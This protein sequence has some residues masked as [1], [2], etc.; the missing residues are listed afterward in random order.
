MQPT[1]AAR[2][3]DCTILPTAASSQIGQFAR[4]LASFRYAH[5]HCE[6]FSNQRLANIGAISLN[7]AVAGHHLQARHPGFAEGYITCARNQGSQK[8]A[9]TRPE[10]TLVGA[11]RR[12]APNLPRRRT[13]AEQV[14]F[15]RLARSKSCRRS[16]WLRQRTLSP[17]TAGR[18]FGALAPTARRARR[19]GPMLHALLCT[20]YT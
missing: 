13:A 7:K 11:G 17:E 14:T 19:L 5:A 1:L 20:L 18:T 10:F 12:V 15:E 8:R 3:T 9:H 16:R 6:P 2:L 4:R